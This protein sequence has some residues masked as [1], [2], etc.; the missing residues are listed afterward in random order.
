[1][2]EP[3]WVSSPSAAEA[4]PSSQAGSWHAVSRVASLKWQLNEART[5]RQSTSYHFMRLRHLE[6]FFGAYHKHDMYYY[7]FAVLVVNWRLSPEGLWRF[8]GSECS[9]K[10][11]VN[12]RGTT[13]YIYHVS[14]SFY[15]YKMSNKSRQYHRRSS[16]GLALPWDPLSSETT[17][18]NI[19]ERT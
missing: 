1:M 7:C 12:I 13:C 2:E 15:R 17:A 16:P 11:D 4:R 3:R 6:T 8:C 9:Q 18:Q 19:T 10:G 14:I 5:H